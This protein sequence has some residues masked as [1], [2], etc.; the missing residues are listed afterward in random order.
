[1]LGVGLYKIDVFSLR[2]ISKHTNRYVPIY[3]PQEVDDK[4]MPQR[5]IIPIPSYGSGIAPSAVPT[6]DFLMY[7]GDSFEA[8]LDFPMDVTGYVWKSSISQVLGSSVSI[9]SFTID[10]VDDDNTKLK[11]SLTADQTALLPEKCYWD[12][13]ATLESDPSFQRTYMRGTVVTTRQVTV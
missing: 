12:I 8:F 9:V 10:F 3:L 5:A 1:M 2:R 4:S 6:Y 11:L 7:E 13:Q